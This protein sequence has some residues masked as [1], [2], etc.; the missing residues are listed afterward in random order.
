M[1]VKIIVQ[2]RTWRS[3][4]KLYLIKGSDLKKK[5][6]LIIALQVFSVFQTCGA[7][8]LYFGNKPFSVSINQQQYFLKWIV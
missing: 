8:K 2:L 1:R 7:Y 4:P 6:K 3:S 5:K